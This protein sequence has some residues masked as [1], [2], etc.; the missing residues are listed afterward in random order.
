MTS[1]S[2]AF[3]LLLLK[4]ETPLSLTAVWISTSLLT[5][6]LPWLRATGQWWKWKK[7]EFRF[8]TRVVS[9]FTRPVSELVGEDV[10]IVV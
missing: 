8:E 6:L 5:M 2:E 4:V 9:T 7:I 3:R 10:P 1:E